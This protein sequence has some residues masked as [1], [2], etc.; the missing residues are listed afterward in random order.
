MNEKKKEGEIVMTNDTQQVGNSTK[1]HKFSGAVQNA[2]HSIK[3]LQAFFTKF[4]NDWSTTL[5]AALAYN[6]LTAIF[7]IAIALLSILGLLLSGLDAHAQDMLIARIQ[8]AFPMSVSSPD[9]AKT[10]L[11]QLAKASGILGIIAVL[12]AIFGG[13]RLFIL[14]EGLFDIIYRLPQ[15]TFLRQNIMAI[16]MLLLFVVLIPLMLLASSGPAFVLSILKNTPLGSIPGSG[17]IF[18]LGGTLGSLIVGWILFQAIYII[19]PNQKI[20]F[21]KSWLGAVIAAVLLQIYLTL[22]PLYAARLL[23]GYVGQVGFAIILLAF[24]YYFAIIILLGA[25]INAFFAEGIPA[26]PGNLVTLVHNTSKRNS[27][28]PTATDAKVADK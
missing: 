1:R 25:E 19:V 21:R 7:P 18:G 22:F 24:F 17:L 12:A 20:S 13:S 23:G 3:P 8:S 5:A 15:R 16:G 2:E 10:L 6:L 27:N 28:Q 11:Q 9:V 26:T 4:T 14:L